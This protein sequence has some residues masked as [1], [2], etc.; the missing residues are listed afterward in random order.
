MKIQF[1]ELRRQSPF[2]SLIFIRA[3]MA[4]E[5]EAVWF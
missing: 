5:K 1:D 4:A 2:A 3:I